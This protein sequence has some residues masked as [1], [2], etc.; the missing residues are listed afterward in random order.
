MKTSK[1]I[2]GDKEINGFKQS[3]YNVNPNDYKTNFLEWEF[4]TAAGHDV[5]ITHN[6]LVIK[7]FMPN[8]WIV[9]S[10]DILPANTVA[11]MCQN[12]TDYAYGWEVYFK[13]ISRYKAILSTHKEAYNRWDYGDSCNMKGVCIYPQRVS[14]GL[15]L[16]QVSAV[17]EH[18]AHNN[19][20]RN[21]SNG[22]NSYGF[23]SVV[24]GK[25]NVLIKTGEL[26]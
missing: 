20:Y 6:K 7:K 17:W 8:E 21:D 2:F 1:I 19:G 15:W 24:D 4:N 22:Y 3:Q 18:L 14:D 9:R 12:I 13:N 11:T 26:S 5:E 16:Q 25:Q 23:Y 10:N